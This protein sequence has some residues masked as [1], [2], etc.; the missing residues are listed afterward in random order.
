[1]HLLLSYY[2]IN[3][4]LIIQ[5]ALFI[6][7]TLHTA[8]LLI[9][10]FVNIGFHILQSPTQIQSTSISSTKYSHNITL[11]VTRFLSFFI[12]KELLTYV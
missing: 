1:M 10:K 4:A 9:Y 11:L 3:N 6:T 2:C 8:S 7:T 12:L 5:I